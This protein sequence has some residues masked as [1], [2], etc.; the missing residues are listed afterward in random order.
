MIYLPEKR[1]LS[2]FKLLSWPLPR[3]LLPWLM[4]KRGL[5]V[6]VLP[7]DREQAQHVLHQQFRIKEREIGKPDDRLRVDTAHYSPYQKLIVLPYSVFVST[8]A[9]EVFLHE[10]GHAFDFL[11]SRRGLLSAQSA[12]KEVLHP[13]RSF[14]DYCK[15]TD[16]SRGN[17]AEQFATAFAA[18]FTEPEPEVSRVTVDHLSSAFIDRMRQKVV[19]PFEETHVRKQQKQSLGYPGRRGH[20]A[21]L[22]GS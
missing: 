4:Q 9:G 5:G 17:L 16:E 8:R 12:W 18:Y 6:C 3:R 11:A 2:Y 1:F 22:S 19:L 14:T 20:S 7:K 15:K 10:V 13:D 21:G